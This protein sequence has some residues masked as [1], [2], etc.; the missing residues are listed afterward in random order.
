M[1]QLSPYAYDAKSTSGAWDD[2]DKDVLAGPTPSP[3]GHDGEE[4]ELAAT[5]PTLD[6]GDQEL[7]AA[8]TSPTLDGGDQELVAAA[9]SPTLDGGEHELAAAATSPTLD[10][11]EHELAAAATSPT[12]KGGDKELEAAAASPTLD[13]GDKE[14]EAAAASPTLDDG[15]KKLEAAA[16]SPTLDGGDKDLGWIAW[17]AAEKKDEKP[18]ADG[19]CDLED[20]LHLAIDGAVLA[21]EVTE[22]NMQDQCTA[23]MRDIERN[24][25]GKVNSLGAKAK[26]KAAPPPKVKQPKAT[27][28]KSKA[29]PLPKGKVS[30][31][32]GKKK[33][34]KEDGK[35]GKEKVKGTR[36]RSKQSCEPVEEP[37][38]EAGAEIENEE[39][40]VLDD[41]ALKKKLASVPWFWSYAC[42]DQA[43]LGIMFFVYLCAAKI[44]SVAWCVA[45]RDKP[46]KNQEWASYAYEVRKKHLG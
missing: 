4:D 28:A 26:V 20:P 42:L 35:S 18:E 15:D 13:G 14:L 9:T 36:A 30:K 37:A 2:L 44:Y 40:I 11:G 32:A 34:A 19:V 12:L 6:G 29:H 8:A 23:L 22:E 45:K 17:D 1:N 5:P 16:A 24:S 3:G 31:P 7:E 25:L 10:D 27:A 21:E 46:G 38:N 43:L 33:V 41:A 39:G